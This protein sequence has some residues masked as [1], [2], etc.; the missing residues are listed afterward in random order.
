MIKAKFDLNHNLITGFKVTGHADS[1][2][3]G[4]DIVC[5]AVSALAISS[6]NGLITVC[7]VDP[8]VKQDEKNGGYLQVKI[9][10]EHWDDVKAQTLLKSFMNGL[11]DISKQY[12]N[13]VEVK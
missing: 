5:A 2:E 7:D 13:Y 3:Y 12:S 11:K 10:D 1:G 9:P 6:V 4:H 8:F